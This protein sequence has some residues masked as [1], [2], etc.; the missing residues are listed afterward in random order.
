MSL[1]VATSRLSENTIISDAEKPAHFINYFRSPIEIEPDSEIAVESVK[2]KRTGNIRITDQNF[3]THHWGQDPLE[4]AKLTTGLSAEEIAAGG[5]LEGGRFQTHVPRPIRLPEKTYELSEYRAKMEEVLNT[6]YGDPRIHNNASVT[7]KTDSAGVEKGVDIKFTS[8]RKTAANALAS[9][10][11]T[12]YFNISRPRSTGDDS[13]DAGI[14][15]SN[16]FSFTPADGNLTRAD[17]A[18][19]GVVD[20]DDPR[21]ADMV[22]VLKDRPLALNGGEHEYEFI[23]AKDNFVISGL[24]RP[25]LQYKQRAGLNSKGVLRERVRDLLPFQWQPGS[26]VASDLNEVPGPR[27]HCD[28]GVMVQ[29]AG[30]AGEKGVFIFNSA[31]QGKLSEAR[32]RHFE[33]KYWESGGVHTGQRMTTPEFYAKYNRIKYVAEYDGISVFFGLTGKAT[34]EQICG[35]NLSK[36]P[37]KCL[38]PIGEIQHALYP[39]I[40][41]GKKAVNTEVISLESYAH[42]YKCPVFGLGTG[43]AP[44]TY[45]PGDDFYSNNRVLGRQ[46]ITATG[47]EEPLYDYQVNRPRAPIKVIKSMEL[48]SRVYVSYHESNS[49][50]EYTFSG[51]NASESADYFHTLTCGIVVK[52]DPGYLALS[53]K[54]IKRPSMGLQLGFPDRALLTQVQGKLDGYVTETSPVVITFG[55]THALEKGA[56]SSFIRLPGLTHKSFNGGQSSMSKIVY[57]VP[58]FSND[59]REVGNLYFAPVEKTYVAL[60]NPSKILLNQLHVQIVDDQE[61]EINSLNGTTQIVFH[62][63]KR[64]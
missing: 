63:R 34:F 4:R 9:T 60:K 50:S 30:G 45:T 18:G 6:M 51:S 29:P 40:S 54:Q 12:S 59:G 26:I 7:I 28:Y 5:T 41:I 32:Q 55:S 27:F 47:E 48:N 44:H 1:V 43:G 17:P 11:A 20:T 52:S 22:V 21:N 33:I 3:F 25:M 37:Q 64:K 42:T 23:A 35:P 56:Q 13:P 57:H 39:V 10:T 16:G 53:S 31:A 62:I 36:D 61:M 19:I 2:L 58:Q 38:K 8:R 14:V 24:T 46:A 49:L 15:P